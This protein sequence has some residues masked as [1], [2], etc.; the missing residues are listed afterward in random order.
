MIHKCSISYRVDHPLHMN[1]QT[2][3]MFIFEI[4]TIIYRFHNIQSSKSLRPYN[5]ISI[6]WG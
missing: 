2:V 4:S 6:S 3:A 5:Y 1:K